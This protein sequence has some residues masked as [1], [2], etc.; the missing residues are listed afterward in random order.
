MLQ[1]RLGDCDVRALIVDL[2]SEGGM[3]LIGYL[4][5]PG[6]GPKERGV[7][8]VAFG[9]HVALEA[10]RGAES[11]GADAVMA[12]G[13]FSRQLPEILRLLGGSGPVQSDLRD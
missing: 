2:E 12:R 10:L 11:A 3:E 13:A 9:P 7:R 8:I 1:A 6:A 5:G 4:R